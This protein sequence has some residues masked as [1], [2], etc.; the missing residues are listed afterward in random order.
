MVF[1]EVDFVT[2]RAVGLPG[3]SCS[4]LGLTP[5]GPVKGS[6]SPSALAARMRKKYSFPITSLRQ[7]NLV[8]EAEQ[9]P[10]RPK[11]GRRDS[12]ISMT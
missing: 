12:R 6:L 2:V 1:S 5:S 8:T 4:F 10:A 9:V 3:A 11:F 7:V